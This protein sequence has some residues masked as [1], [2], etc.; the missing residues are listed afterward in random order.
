[1]STVAEHLAA[2]EFMLE[3]KYAREH[4]LRLYSGFT[5]EAAMFCEVHL[6]EL[7]AAQTPEDMAAAREDFKRRI[8]EQHPDVAERLIAA[9]EAATAKGP[10]D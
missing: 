1:M 8:R 4:T 7:V 6:K 9:V 10:H 3:L 2:L 5:P